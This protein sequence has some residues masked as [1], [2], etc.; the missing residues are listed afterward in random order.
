MFRFYRNVVEEKKVVV[1]SVEQD[2]L[3]RF[4]LNDVINTNE[5]NARLKSLEDIIAALT[6]T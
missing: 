6:A 4:Y 2:N 5:T 3:I 1:H